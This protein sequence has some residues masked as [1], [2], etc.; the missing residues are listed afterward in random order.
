MR[1]LNRCIP[2]ALAAGITAAQTLGS[3]EP[4]PPLATQG[5][6]H[7]VVR[8]DNLWDL[9]QTY[10]GNPFLW[11]EIYRLN[12][13]VVEDPHWI[14]P[15]EVL[16][17]PGDAGPV[18]SQIP[19]GGIPTPAAPAL[20]TT[21]VDSGPPVNPNSP[22]VF[23]RPIGSGGST[24]PPAATGVLGIV[25]LLDKPTLRAGE[26]LVAPYVD[27]EGGPRGYGKIVKVAELPG[28]G[29]ST[30]R[31]SFQP[32]DKVLISPPV[33]YVAPVGE[34]YLA[35]RLGPVLEDQG[36]IVIPTGVVEVHSAARSGTGAVAKVVRVF[37]E[38]TTNDRLSPLDTAG[39][40]TTTRPVRVADGP[41][42]MI[43]W[44]YG[45]PVLPSLQNF[46]VLNVSSRNGVRM[47]DEFIIYKP[48]ADPEEGE[49]RE[50]ET[51]IAK[52]QVVRSTPYGVS[53]V[54]IG[55]EQPHIKEGMTARLSAK[56]P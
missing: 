42:A 7:T 22:T 29:Q 46:I 54:I 8:G 9:S 3:Q 38:V 33:G 10:L 52:A 15:G 25:N 44:I 12:R 37:S 56:M 45:E 21:P 17:L 50:R 4:T 41:N 36:Q 35:V 18:V 1:T 31:E 23:G 55:Q 13:D 40:G 5:R 19:E 2:L 6:T 32:Y 30:D 34:R 53:A 43:K 14:Y 39:V 16:R 47:G 49:P 27:R 51:L 48:S 20:P 26:V 28:V 11:P 24:V